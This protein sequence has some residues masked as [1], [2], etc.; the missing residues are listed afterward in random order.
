MVTGVSICFVNESI[1]L[2]SKMCWG[3]QFQSC[4]VRERYEC[5]YACVSVMC[6]VFL[7]VC[8]TSTLFMLCGYVCG[9]MSMCLFVI[10]YISVSVCADVKGVHVYLLLKCFVMPGVCV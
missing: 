1:V 2:D 8:V 9:S 7:V 6:L 10:L 3:S 4:M 5:L